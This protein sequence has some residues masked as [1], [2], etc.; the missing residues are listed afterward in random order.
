[1]ESSFFN[2]GAKDAGWSISFKNGEK[3]YADLV[4]AADGAHSKIRPYITPIKSFYT[5]ITMLEGT[6]EQ[7]SIKAPTI[8]ALLK[9]GKLMAF[10]DN[11]NL[12]L[13][14]KANG[15]IGFYASLKIE[16]EW[17][18]N[19]TTF[20][21]DNT[22]MLQWFKDTYS[23]WDT[24]WFELFNSASIFIPRPIYCMPLEQHW[25]TKFNLTLLGDAAHVMPPFAGE[26]VNMALL[27]ALELSN[28]LFSPIF[29]TIE[30]ALKDYETKMLERTS[31]IA[32]ESIDNGERMHSSNSLNE[33][34]QFFQQQ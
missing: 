21:R 1:M 13:G 24:V 5:G 9:G 10:G 2:H 17:S 3:V 14:Q 30:D 28:N 26:G 29:I 7:A 8:N 16:E 22:I 20:F 12:L 11:K 32:K 4:I 15:E 18:K 19:N 27:D 6:I 31:K 34:L 23:T 33:M 25:E